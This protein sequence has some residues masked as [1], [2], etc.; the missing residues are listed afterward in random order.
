LGRLYRFTDHDL[1]EIEALLSR[2]VP[3]P[4]IVRPSSQ[5]RQ[6]VASFATSYPFYAN[7]HCL[8]SGQANQNEST[9]GK[10]RT[11]SSANAKLAHLPEWQKVPH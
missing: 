5:P 10:G 1:D 11:N 8:N 4:S 7:I 2:R 6:P 3:R 9:T